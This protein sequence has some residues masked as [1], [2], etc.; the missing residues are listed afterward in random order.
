M[1]LKYN[2]QEILEKKIK[3]I[4]ISALCDECEKELKIEDDKPIAIEVTTGHDAWGNDSCESIENHYLC[5]GT[6]LA[7]FI[8]KYAENIK[9][10]S[11]YIE[12]NAYNG[13]ELQ[14]LIK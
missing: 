13:K 5:S 4:L 10:N 7:K 9:H 1:S 6:C 3:N 12:I 2:R 14:L 11:S 8:K